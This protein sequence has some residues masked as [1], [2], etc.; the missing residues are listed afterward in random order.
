VLAPRCAGR[1]VAGRNT[2]P[3]VRPLRQL[4][5]RVPSRPSIGRPAQR[6]FLSSRSRLQPALSQNVAEPARRG[7]LQGRWIRRSAL[8]RRA[9]SSSDRPI[10]IGDPA[11]SP[12][13]QL[14]T[15]RRPHRLSLRDPD[16]P[17]WRRFLT[18]AVADGGAQIICAPGGL[19]GRLTGARS[20]RRSGLDWSRGQFV[21]PGPLVVIRPDFITGRSTG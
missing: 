2:T 12:N 18:Y 1:P 19:I 10:V 5:P 13:R 11:Q 7:R 9:R 4:P 3:Q 8:S 16:R 15:V 14:V 6:P 21:E 17:I 20:R